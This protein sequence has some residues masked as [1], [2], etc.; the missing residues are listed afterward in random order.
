MRVVVSDAARADLRS[1]A[2]SALKV[3]GATGKAEYLAVLLARFSSLLEHPES[4][5]PRD[6]L[7]A[8]CRSLP[9]GGHVIF[10]SIQNDAIH[11]FRVLHQ[12][13]DAKSHL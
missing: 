7:S 1:I 11:I 10:H 3:W 8:G 5:K 4:G 2:D 12:R 13:M 6:E 9:A